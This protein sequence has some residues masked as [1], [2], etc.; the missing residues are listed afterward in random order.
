LA[1]NSVTKSKVYP[2]IN[3]DCPANA[4]YA[5]SKETTLCANKFQKS[6]GILLFSRQ[7]S[8]FFL[9]KYYDIQKKESPF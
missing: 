9:I 1:V 3:N 5:S 4:F 8:S 2:I 7:I 6:D